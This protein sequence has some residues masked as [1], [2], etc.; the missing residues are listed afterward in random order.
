[1]TPL[2]KGS[3][4]EVGGCHICLSLSK[5]S[6]HRIFNPCKLTVLLKK[7]KNFKKVGQTPAVCPTP[8]SGSL[9]PP[10]QH[11]VPSAASRAPDLAPAAPPSTAAAH[12][13]TGLLAVPRREPAV[14]LRA[15]AHAAPASWGLPRPP[16][17]SPSLPLGLAVP[18]RHTFVCFSAQSVLQLRHVPHEASGYFWVHGCILKCL[19]QSLA[20]TCCS[21]TS[22]DRLE[23]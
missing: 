8:S 9:L 21:Q 7:I 20:R 4:L 14:L 2:E 5:S 22:V 11:K 16:V 13:H 23:L 17:G 10:S 15:G 6:Y 18:S 12:V 1:M 19:A 3:R